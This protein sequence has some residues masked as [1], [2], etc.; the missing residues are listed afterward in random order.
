[1]KSDR[2]IVSAA[3]YKPELGSCE[4]VTDELVYMLFAHANEFTPLAHGAVEAA[5]PVL[6]MIAFQRAEPSL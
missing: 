4:V 6:P 2:W 5:L 3:K 1:V